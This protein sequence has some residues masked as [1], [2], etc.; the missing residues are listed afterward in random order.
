MGRAQEV[1][2]QPVDQRVRDLVRHDVAREAEVDAPARLAQPL[3]E[4]ARLVP[5]EAHGTEV[6]VVVRIGLL[7]G[8]RMKAQPA[9]APP[10]GPNPGIAA[11]RR[12]RP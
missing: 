8:M 3:G 9:V 7:E 5:A 6:A 10:I 11:E 12:K 1:R 4:L 2:A